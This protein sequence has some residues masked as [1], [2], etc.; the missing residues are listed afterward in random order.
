MKTK[1]FLSLAA[2]FAVVFAFF[3]CSSDSPNEP[4]GQG[5]GEQGGEQQGGDS[6]GG[7]QVNNSSSSSLINSSSSIKVTCAQNSL[8]HGYNVIKSAYIRGTEGITAD[9]ILD[10]DKMCADN[11]I[12]NVKATIQDYNSISGTSI[13]Q[14]YKSDV[15]A[16]NLNAKYSTV[17]FSGG[18][19]TEFEKATTENMEIQ[20]Y[21]SRWRYYAYTQED[22]IKETTN[23]SKYLTES[24]KSYIQAQAN[25]P[26]NIFTKFGTHV[27][28]RYYKGGSLAANYTYRG[29]KL[30]SKEDVQKALNASAGYAGA[31]VGAEFKQGTA[32]ERAELEKE[33]VFSF[34]GCGGT[35][36]SG[37]NMA[38]LQSKYSTW[39]NDIEKNPDICGIG[40]FE[41]AFIPIWELVKEG[42][43]PSIASVLEA[44]FNDIA[45]AQGKE[46]L[47]RNLV[48]DGEWNGEKGGDKYSYTKASKNNP[49][50]IEI[51][52]LGAGG[53][54]QGGDYNDGAVNNNFGTGGAGGGGGAAYV[55]MRI[56]EPI[57]LDITVG[58]YVGGKGGN[59]IKTGGGGT[60][61]SGCDGG[62]GG[63]TIV[64][65]DAKGITITAEGGKGGNGNSS[66][67]EKGGTGTAGG[68]GGPSYLSPMT[69]SLYLDK[70]DGDGKS[71][72]NGSDGNIKSDIES[73]GGRAAIINKGTLAPWGGEYGGYRPKG[74]AETG[75]QGPG[76]GGGGSGGSYYNKV[77]YK[78]QDGLDGAVNI[79]VRRFADEE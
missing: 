26:E 34:S 39:V 17:L 48:L 30:S 13:K 1:R 56:E 65:W 36:I 15:K 19:S 46:L 33:S 40:E 54:G 53:G 52:A 6:S 47:V 32:T 70:E 23:L 35:R 22:R 61:T 7:S 5:G 71:G 16:V 8:G 68:T 75:V 10:Q 41:K 67:K 60:N 45:I 25:N 74:S 12:E 37:Q 76:K 78:G 31:K 57:T 29:T 27:L 9:L 64:K 44:K 72:G 62:K 38:E 66:C 21:Y 28:I 11:I 77:P 49:A 58:G 43:Y 69:H 14:L 18:V 3:A 73:I 63:N 79:V 50:L 42:G 59:P 55:K 51:Y 20:Y 2:I 4:Q 24:F